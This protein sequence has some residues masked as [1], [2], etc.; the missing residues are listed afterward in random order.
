MRKRLLITSSLALV[1]GLG[2]AGGLSLAKKD[3]KAVEAVSAGEKVY[4]LPNSDWLSSNARF[5]MYY[6]GNGDGWVSMTKNSRSK[7]YEATIPSGYTT[8]ILCRMNGSTTENSWANKWNQTSDLVL[9]DSDSKNVYQITG[10]DNSGAWLT[11]TFDGTD[12]PTTNGYY[13]MSD[14]TSFKFANAPKMTDVTGGDVAKLL[15]YSATNGEKIKVRGYFDSDDVPNIWSNYGG[16]AQGFGAA[17]GEGNFVFSTDCTVDIYAKYEGSD[18]KFYLSERPANDGYYMLGD[19]NFVSEMGQTGNAWTFV[20]STKMNNVSGD[21]VANYVITATKKVEFRVQKYFSDSG[22]WLEWGEY[23]TFDDDIKKVG[24]NVQLAAGAYSIYVNGD[25]EVYIG[26]GIA[27]DAYC[28]LFLSKT[29]AVCNGDS[30]VRSALLSAMNKMEDDWAFLSTSDKS[31]L[32][33]ASASEIG[34]DAEKVA[35]RYDFILGK[36]GYAAGSGNFHDFMGRTPSRLSAPIIAMLSNNGI[37]NNNTMIIIV[38]VSILAV[39]G[40][41][42]YFF[43]RRKKDN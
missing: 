28:E 26:K 22:E 2:V 12:V 5:A 43:L 23:Q 11:S 6:F 15:S 42:G 38:V 29:G 1:L 14:K 41:G 10:W 13:L 17:D 19:S 31:T 7:Y 20:S 24:N 8:I 21:N 3:A 33:G 35:A 18:L 32:T 27:L 40:V 30:T 4:L 9:D 37:S 39:A 36:Y 25:E 34:T 16:T